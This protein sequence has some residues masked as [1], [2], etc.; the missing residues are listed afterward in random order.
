MKWLTSIT[1]LT[2]VFIITSFVIDK[3][4]AF[5]F[6][7]MTLGMA[8]VSFLFYYMTYK[9]N[10]KQIVGN[11]AA[12][13]V[14]FILSA[15]VVVTYFLLTKSKNRIDY[16]FFLAAYLAYSIVSYWGAYTFIK[17]QSMSKL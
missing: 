1:P 2:I 4:L 10:Q 8:I 6:R 3:N 9:S 5:T 15:V 12:I 11:I 16:L 13:V 14:K 7:W 17:K